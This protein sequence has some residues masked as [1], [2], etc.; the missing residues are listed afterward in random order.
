MDMAYWFLFFVLLTIAIL[1]IS[2][3]I[4]ICRGDYDE[5]QEALHGKGYKSG[6]FAILVF[7]VLYISASA[8]YEKLHEYGFLAIVAGI[9]LG[10][11][12][13][14][15]YFIMHDTFFAVKQKPAAYLILTVILAVFNLIP[16]VEDF[17]RGVN[18]YDF[19]SGHRLISLLCGV[20]FLVFTG[21][22]ITKMLGSR[23]EAEE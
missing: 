3:K 12:V 23:R 4:K 11:S 15:L 1:I 7:F 10:C 9:F 16:P 13:A 6:F 18:S 20:M 17:I 14:S 22:L 21:A 2:I 19:I 5:R 8:G